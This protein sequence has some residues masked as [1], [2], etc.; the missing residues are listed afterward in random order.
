MS[1]PGVCDTEVDGMGEV[2]DDAFGV[3]GIPRIS[4]MAADDCE[5]R[6]LDAMCL[7][8]CLT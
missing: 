2:D 4:A 7:A 6:R 8:R 1:V 3:G 5:A